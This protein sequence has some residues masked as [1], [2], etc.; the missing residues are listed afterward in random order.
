MR[1]L[2]TSLAALLLALFSACILAPFGLDSSS[3]TPDANEGDA[4]ADGD[5]DEEPDADEAPDAGEVPDADEEGVRERCGDGVLDAGEACDDGNTDD[6]DG[7]AGDCSSLEEGWTCP[8]PGE[9]C[10]P[11]YVIRPPTRSLAFMPGSTCPDGWDLEMRASGRLVLGVIDGEAVGRTSGFSLAPGEPLTHTHEY[12]ASVDI[13]G[14]GV[15]GLSGCCNESVGQSGPHEITGTMAA[16]EDHVPR[17]QQNL[18]GKHEDGVPPAD[19]HPFPDDTI[20]FFDAPACPEGWTPVAHADGRFIVPTPEG[21]TAGESFGTPILDGELA[22][23]THELS[24]ELFIP[25]C[26]LAAGGGGNTN[27]VLRGTYSLAGTSS[28]IEA[29]PPHVQFL[30]C[31]AA[32]QPPPPDHRETREELPPTGTLAFFE[33]E[34][35]PEG[36]SRSL[37]HQGRFM[38]GLIE[39]ATPMTTE[40]GA[41][42]APSEVRSHTHGVATSINVASHRLSLASGCCFHS[43]GCHGEYHISASTAETSSQLPYL[44]LLGCTLD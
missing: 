20:L 23:H 6:D 24:L 35:C 19:A 28:E 25:E 33:A 39:S 11:P 10:L 30:V 8:V 17:I 18:C 1:V 3:D 26:S 9:L 42:L 34:T 37:S 14:T 22:G 5:V 36:W 41:P 27:P 38:L 12:W 32:P 31:R 2:E 29:A 40:G 44:S 15:G 4:G 16:C 21:G 7:C 43:S 13:P